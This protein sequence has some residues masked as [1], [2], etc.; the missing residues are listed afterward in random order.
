[1]KTRLI[2]ALIFIHLVGCYGCINEYRTLLSGEVKS[3]GKVSGKVYP[4]NIDTFELK[5]SAELLLKEYRVT[6]DL[7]V[8]SDYAAVLVYVGRYNEAKKIY[9]DIEKHT[10]NL[11]TTASNL[12]TIYEL[13]GK[14]DSALYWIKKAVELEPNSHFGSEWIHVK[15]LEH[16]LSPVSNFKGSVLGLDFGSDKIPQNPNEYNL[17]QLAFHI[18]HQ[19]K[20]RTTFVKPKNSIV[21]NIYFD[22]G[23]ILAQLFNVEAG[24]GSYYEAKKYGFDSELLELRNEALEKL[25]QKRSPYVILGKLKELISRNIVLQYFLIICSIVLF[26][27]ILVKIIKRLFSN[28]S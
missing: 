12:G 2:I 22:Y 5:H 16:K 13:T 20:E 9:F 8:Y 19:L 26:F 21:G 4:N 7:K 1:M 18:E 23:N 17:K 11:Y 6:K 27:F 15:I 28:Y 14:V 10:P 25:S 24:L 3:L